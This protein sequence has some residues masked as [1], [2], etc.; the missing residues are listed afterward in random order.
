MQPVRVIDYPSDREFT[1]HEGIVQELNFRRANLVYQLSQYMEALY[2]LEKNP[3]LMVTT[4]SYGNL[5][6]TSICQMR[7]NS[8]IE[9]RGAVLAL[10]KMLDADNAGTLDT[11]WSDEALSFPED[12]RV[13][14]P[15]NANG[16]VEEDGEGK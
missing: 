3:G 16:E 5:S 6:I 2:R 13:V 1:F 12:G 14:S 11:L 7:Y 10:E 15:L 4:Q 9:A 8:V